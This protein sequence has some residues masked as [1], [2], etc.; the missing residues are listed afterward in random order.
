MLTSRILTCSGGKPLL[1]PCLLLFRLMHQYAKSHSTLTEA[2]FH[3]PR[4]V[5]SFACSNIYALCS[6]IEIADLRASIWRGMNSKQEFWLQWIC[7]ENLFIL[8]RFVFWYKIAL[9]STLGDCNRESS[10][11]SQFNNKILSLNWK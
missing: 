7:R 1:F 11:H 4:T 9:Q 8:L 3:I 5:H 6:C 2:A 10:R